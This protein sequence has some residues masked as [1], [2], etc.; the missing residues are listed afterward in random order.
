MAISPDSK[1]AITKRAKGGPLNL[2]P[3]GA[4][5]TKELTH[6]A[7]SYGGARFFPDG[8]RLLASG[9]E[10]GH[11]GR[12][13]VIDLSSGD[14]KPVTPE[15]M[16]GVQL[17][18]DG[19]SVAVR[20]AD[21]KR[22]IWSLEKGE[23]R[24]IPGLEAKD[25]VIGWTLDGES[26]YVAPF[27]RGAKVIPVFRANIETG[28]MEPWKSFGAEIGAQGATLVPPHLSSDGAAYA[29]IYSR[30]LS[31]AYVVTGLK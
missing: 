21:G 3:T 15:G 30:T 2:V 8:K 6:D 17:S 28:K 18:P 27:V 23:F 5:E 13:Y 4:G 9:I 22:G 20:A 29:Y 7:V 1:W 11:G 24:A 10:T 14:S 12:D 16:A 26:V 19:K 31:E 25:Y